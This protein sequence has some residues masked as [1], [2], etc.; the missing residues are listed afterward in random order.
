[1]GSRNMFLHRTYY[2]CPEKDGSYYTKTMG[3]RYLTV[4]NKVKIQTCHYHVPPDGFSKPDGAAESRKYVK[5]FRA[6][7]DFLYL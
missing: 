4:V 5:A 1:M 6:V 2:S 7:A 3:L